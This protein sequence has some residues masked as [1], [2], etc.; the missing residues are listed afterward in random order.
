MTDK[1]IRVDC[2]ICGERFGVLHDDKLS[3]MTKASARLFEE[4]HAW[5]CC[6]QCSS[7]MEE[8][9]RRRKAHGLQPIELDNLLK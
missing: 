3:F 7:T 6:F 1:T 9:N 8:L 4:G 2:Q 5:L